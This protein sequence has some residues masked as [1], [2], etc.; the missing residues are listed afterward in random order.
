[1]TLVERFGQSI[2]R[3]DGRGGRALVALSGG[4]DSVALLDLLLRTR[5]QHG[6]DLVVGHV[7]H[8]IHP[9]SARVAEQVRELAGGFQLPVEIGALALGPATTETR[10]R[11]ARYAWLEETRVRLDAD[12]IMTAHHADDQAETVLMRVLAGSGPAGLAGM[13]SRQGRLVRPLLPYRRAELEEHL[14][15]V[16]LSGWVDPANTDPRHLRS[17]IRTE[18]LPLLRGRVPDMERNLERLASQ[19][20]S[21]RAAWDSLLDHLPGLDVRRET[22]GISV[23]ASPFGDYDS[24][25]TQATIFALAR[26]T[27][28]QLGP[29][30]AARVLALLRAGSSGTRVPLGGQWTAELSFGRLRI[31]RN[32]SECPPEPWALEG[33]R[34]SAAW[35]RWRFQWTRAIAPELQD[36][37]GLSAWFTLEPLTIRSWAPGDR[38]RPLGG[39]GQRLIVRCF[40]DARVPRSSR[41]FWPVLTSPE[42]VLWVPGV[43]RS[44]ARVPPGGMEALRV[45]AQYA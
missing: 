44:E 8:G 5:D 1:M 33:D 21:D 16:G 2:Q 35:G 32:H 12:F 39:T 37:S 41:G 27:G 15:S 24:A 29:S 43:C 11:E 7:D 42:A 22:N 40:Q 31:C 13:A 34:G 9:D 23:A 20:A 6:L 36:R 25:L 45:D 30:R 4:P 17:W 14:K 3:F 10:S 38:V 28:C 19:A 26:R 18:L